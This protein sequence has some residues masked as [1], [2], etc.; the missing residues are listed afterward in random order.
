MSEDSSLVN[1]CVNLALSFRLALN[2]FAGVS[3]GAIFV[4]GMRRR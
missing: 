2:G 4:V 3:L 1:A